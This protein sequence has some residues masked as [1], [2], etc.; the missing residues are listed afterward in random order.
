MA[1][2]DAP[3]PRNAEGTTLVLKDVLHFALLNL[4]IML[5]DLD[6]IVELKDDDTGAGIRLSTARVSVINH[7]FGWHS[8]GITLGGLE[9]ALK[10]CSLLRSFCIVVLDTRGYEVHPRDQLQTSGGNH[11]RPLLPGGWQFWTLDDSSVLALPVVFVL[12]CSDFTP[13]QRFYI[14]SLGRKVLSVTRS[15]RDT[16]RRRREA[17]GRDDDARAVAAMGNLIL[18]SRW[19]SEVDRR[20]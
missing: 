1:Y 18:W 7:T 5:I 15:L 6:R 3:D 16:A 14:S 17:G 9:H 4:T 13:G 11:G 19:A 12:F 10:R 20:M 2:S 8:S